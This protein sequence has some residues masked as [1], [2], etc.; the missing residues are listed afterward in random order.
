MPDKSQISSNTGHL[1]PYIAEQGDVMAREAALWA[2]NGDA[3]ALHKLR[4]AMRRAR[5]AAK[6]LRHCA[7][8]DYIQ[9]LEA[10]LRWMSKSTGA[11]RDCDVLLND[12]QKQAALLPEDLGPFAAPIFE[13]L[14]ICQAQAHDIVTHALNSSRFKRVLGVM[15]A[16]TSHSINRDE[17]TALAQRA[18]AKTYKKLRKS[19]RTLGDDCRDADIH[20]IR[21]KG[22]ALRY[23]LEL[24]TPLFPNDEAT[25]FI[26][27]M[28]KQQDKLGAFQDSAVQGTSLAQCFARLRQRSPAVPNESLM[29]LGAFWGTSFSDKQR[30]R[31]AILR[32]SRKFPFGKMHK[33]FKCL[34]DALN[35][36]SDDSESACES[37]SS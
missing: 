20:A 18:L 26:Q 5:T 7:D 12:L 3:D 31:Q 29:L 21:K 16:A 2:Q 33:D 8:K 19:A 25:V 9:A 4:V 11:A 28:K 17:E 1:F 30:C 15:E 24:F 35:S 10:D 27:K 36:Q 34:L 37:R 23:F 6:V 32:K 22:K 14:E 13:D